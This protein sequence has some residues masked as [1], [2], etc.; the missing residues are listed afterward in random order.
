MGQCDVAVGCGYERFFN[1]VLLVG[2][3]LLAGKFSIEL[4]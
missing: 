3:S 4:V 1:S 2:F